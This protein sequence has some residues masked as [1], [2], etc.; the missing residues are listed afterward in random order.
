MEREARFK[1]KV[2]KKG[3]TKRRNAE[4][5]KMI[6]EEEKKQEEANILGNAWC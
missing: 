3:K 6:Q 1:E 2:K 4:T 5:M